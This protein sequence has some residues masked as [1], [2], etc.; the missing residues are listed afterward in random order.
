MAT[1]RISKP[2]Q[3]ET[4]SGTYASAAVRGLALGAHASDPAAFAAAGV[5]NFIGFLQR[6]VT[7]DGPA[8]LDHMLPGRT[9][10]DMPFKAGGFVAVEK[11][12][13]V[14]A[15]GTAYLDTI[16][17]IT[18]IGTEVT[19]IA[20]KF[21]PVAVGNTAFYFVSAILGADADGDQVIRFHRI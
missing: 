4:Y 18:A 2:D 8:L 3:G 21:K 9:E 1:F 10:L 12:E 5:N 7:A 11:G 6:A 17:E 20:G 13:E 19:F 15:G 16:S 14:E